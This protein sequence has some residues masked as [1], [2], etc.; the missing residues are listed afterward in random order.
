M[1]T[2]YSLFLIVLS[3]KIKNNQINVNKKIGN[4]DRNIFFLNII[5]VFIIMEEISGNVQICIINT[6]QNTTK[7][8]FLKQ[9]TKEAIWYIE[10]IYQEIK[11]MH[12]T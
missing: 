6:K 10:A 2:A 11:K 1:I 12:F 9:Y 4:I 8:V 5:E 3:S 7:N